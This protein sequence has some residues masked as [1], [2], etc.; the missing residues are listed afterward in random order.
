MKNPSASPATPDRVREA[1]AALAGVTEEMSN[2]MDM[3]RLDLDQ[4]HVAC[5]SNSQ[6]N[7]ETFPGFRKVRLTNVPHK[8]SDILISYHVTQKYKHLAV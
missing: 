4:S 6:V 5:T 3:L 2:S 8:L 1:E 7:L